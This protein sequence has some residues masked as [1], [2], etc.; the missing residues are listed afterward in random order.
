MFKWAWR[1]KNEAER[2]I[3]SPNNRIKCVFNLKNSQVFY[4]VYKNDKLIIK[5]SRLGFVVCG[6]TPLKDQLSL[7][8]T[9]TKK[10]NET[11]ELLWGEDH[12]I[13]N[14]YSESAFFLAESKNSR[15]L[16]TIRFRVFDNG[17]AFRYEIPP[18][19]KFQRITIADEL[20]EFNLD[21]N[22]TAWK[23]P[24]YQP[25]RYEYS[26]EKSAVYDLR[27][28]VHTP[29]TLRTPN[30][31]Y[32]SIHEASLYNYGAMTIQLNQNQVLQSDITPLSDG[33]RAHVDLP[34]QTPWRLIMIADSAIEL[35]TNRLIYAL[36]D[37][38]SADFSW[39]KPLKF[40][41]I[42]WAMY[43]GEWTWAPGERHGATTEHAKEYIDSATRLG[44]SGLLIEGWN[45]GWEGDWL[46][47]GI[48]NNFTN[49]TPDFDFPAVARYATAHNIELV[50]HH[51]TVGFIDNYEA[52]IESAY[53]YYASNNVHYIKTGYA[54]SMMTING[55]REYHHS[56]LG[57]LHYQKTIELAAKKHICLDI[58]EPI[59]GTGIERTWPNLLSREGARGQEYEGG[60][61]SP[62]HACFLPYTRLLAGGMD[63]TN[64][65]FDLDNNAKRINTTLARQIAYFIT[66][67]SGMAMAADRPFI[68][69]ERFP[70][71][72]D[73]I[74]TVPIDFERTLPL[75][76]EVG[77]YY[78]VAR[79]A[80]G[81]QD[82]YIGGVADEYGR[83]ATIS[84]DFLPDGAYYA[85]IYSDTPESHYRDN[86]FAISISEKHV[87]KN[88]L[89][90]IFIAPG[91][92][93]AIQLRKINP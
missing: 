53:N 92:G 86:P 50:G 43:V 78:I 80:R 87:G 12:L 32:L 64:G 8:R 22:T 89:L 61:L 19:P 59:K 23:I 14:N 40:I 82:W 83:R 91:G 58:H 76:G 57:V 54:G 52:Q 9:T 25:D 34:F 73:F 38:P 24:A 84:L 75:A 6:E 45:D 81:S 18:Q 60:T 1:Q 17:V 27:R 2:E 37:P 79:Q 13:P 31:Y 11:I 39:V 71:V 46:K 74:R 63:Y 47:N 3:F 16:Y 72:F 44:I 29:L 26:Y 62:S 28:P 67:Y 51:E 20:T 41:G 10:H 93:F 33:T 42:W 35:T 4:R 36:N 21:L 7:V 90:D 70:Q 68:Y 66:I 85:K 5:P 49:S 77:E 30:G 88:D 69:E 48:H 56:Q 15:R 55:R 65:I